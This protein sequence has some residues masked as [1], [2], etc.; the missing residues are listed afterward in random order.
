MVNSKSSSTRGR[1]TLLTDAAVISS[2]GES[3]GTGKQSRT[4]K[5]GGP[6]RRFAASRLCLPDLQ[7]VGHREDIANILGRD[8]REVLVG[9]VINVALQGDVQILDDDADVG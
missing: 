1:V 2:I 4:E 6:C 5:S 3:T 8:G 9:F 7:V